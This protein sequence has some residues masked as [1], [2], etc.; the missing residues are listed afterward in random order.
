M[1]V[2]AVCLV[3]VVGRLDVRDRVRRRWEEDG[4]GVEGG[5]VGRGGRGGEGG[6][7]WEE[8]DWGKGGGEVRLCVKS[9]EGEEAVSRV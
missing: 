9:G 1:D 7:R 2:D 5:K 4:V 6:R 3:D 8:T